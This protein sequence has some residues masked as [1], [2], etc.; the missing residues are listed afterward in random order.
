MKITPVAANNY[1]FYKK[2]SAKPAINQTLLNNTSADYF[3]VYKNKSNFA[4][5]ILFLGYYVHIFDSGF[6]GENMEHFAKAIGDDMD[7]LMHNVDTNPKYPEDKQMKSL[8]EELRKIPDKI[9][10]K[11]EYIAIPAL[12]TVSLQNIQVQY[13]S[14]MG[15]EIELTPENIKRNKSKLIEFLKEIYN[16]RDKHEKCI[17]YMDTNTQGVEYA[18][19]VILEINR[20]VKSGYKV[21]MPTGHPIHQRLKRL[22]EEQDRKPELEY[23]M[24]SGVDIEN[25]VYNM[26]NYIKDQGWYDFNLLALSDA[27]IIN[28]SDREG[29]DFLYSAYDN[30]ITE[31]ARGVYNFIR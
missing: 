31:S 3:S 12:C 19:K 30:T 27:N 24:A 25:S 6:H 10:D 2:S 5:G 17:G 14:V 22:A 16:N 13:K 18:Y 28:M 1:T 21:Y 7:V 11:D 15:E 26:K 29:N 23:Y 8:Y 20:L 4:G 9:G